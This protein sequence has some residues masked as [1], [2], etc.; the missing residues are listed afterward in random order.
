MHDI[1]FFCAGIPFS[2]ND[3]S[4]STCNEEQ[5]IKEVAIIISIIEIIY[6]TR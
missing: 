4:D 6:W 3:I 5:V 2:M 1:M